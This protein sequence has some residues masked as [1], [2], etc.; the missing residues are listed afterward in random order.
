[1]QHGSVFDKLYLKR[2]IQKVTAI[3]NNDYKLSNIRLVIFTILHVSDILLLEVKF[4]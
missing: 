2:L 3:N 4:G 1:M